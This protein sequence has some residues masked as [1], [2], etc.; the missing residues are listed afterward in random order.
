LRARL[1]ETSREALA[2][3]NDLARYN[4]AVENELGRAYE[5]TE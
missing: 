3:I 4:V 5:E 1:D 2:L